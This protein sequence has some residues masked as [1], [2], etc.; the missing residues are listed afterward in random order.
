MREPFEAY[1]LIG[2]S[3]GDKPDHALDALARKAMPDRIAE[4]DRL[5]ASQGHPSLAQ[6]EAF[7]QKTGYPLLAEALG[8]EDSFEIGAVLL[9][10]SARARNALR[11]TGVL[12]ELR[13]ML[14]DVFGFHAPEDVSAIRDVFARYVLF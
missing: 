6:L 13:R 4:I 3:L 2:A 12:D 1:A 10:D 7:A 14:A 9:L 5:F 11:K 8:T